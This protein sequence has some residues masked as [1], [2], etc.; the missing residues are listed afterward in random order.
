VAGQLVIREAMAGDADDIARVHVDTWQTAY[1]GILPADVIA[2]HS[3]EQR[4]QYWRTAL[5]QPDH[6]LVFVAEQDGHVLGFAS[7]GP[8]RSGDPQFTGELYALYIL[9]KYQNRGAG[10]ALVRAIARRL[11]RDGMTSM[12]VWVLADNPARSFYV[13]LGAVEIRQQPIQMGTTT[14]GEVAY[15]WKDLRGLITPRPGLATPY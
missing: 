5:R 9:A 14:V 4:E 3:Y 10:Q 7:G 2:A 12:L 6:E 13:H 8:E 15:G 11:A 1:D